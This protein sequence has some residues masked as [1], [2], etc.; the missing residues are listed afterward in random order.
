MKIKQV[1][2]LS[3][4]LTGVIIV[5][6][7]SGNF[8]QRTVEER[9]QAAH[10][11]LDSAFKFEA[12]KETKIDSAFATYYRAQDKIR[13]ELRSGGERPDF[14]TI[15]TKMQPAIE[16]RDKELKILLTE[17]E[18]KKWKDEIEPSMMQRRGG[19]GSGGNRQ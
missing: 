7:Q 16:A 12:A 1:L 10:E 14:E 5:N 13:E 3:L 8:R 6:A 18:F 2:F 9:V 17:A 11:K 19:G 15:R 4:M